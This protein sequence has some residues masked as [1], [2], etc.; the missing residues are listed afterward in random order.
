MFTTV[1]YLSICHTPPVNTPSCR[2]PNIS[3]LSSLLR[4]LQGSMG[5]HWTI[6]YP[7]YEIIC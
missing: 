6:K 2:R 4:T 3:G 1:S 7:K 5:E